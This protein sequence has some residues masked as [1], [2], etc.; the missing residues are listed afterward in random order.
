MG[1]PLDAD[2]Y[3]LLLAAAEDARNRLGPAESEF[4]DIEKQLVPKEGKLIKKGNAIK[5][6]YTNFNKTDRDRQTPPS[7]K[8]FANRAAPDDASD[9]DEASTHIS[10]MTSSRSSSPQNVP[11]EVLQLSRAS[12]QGGA[13]PRASLAPPKTDPLTLE[14]LENK[15]VLAGFSTGKLSPA[16][17]GL[18]PS[19]SP[20]SVDETFLDQHAPDLQ[21]GRQWS[22]TLNNTNNKDPSADS[23]VTMNALPELEGDETNFMD[24]GEHEYMNRD[25]KISWSKEPGSQSPLHRHRDDKIFAKPRNRVNQWLLHQL[26]ISSWARLLDAVVG[27]ATWTLAMR[28]CAL[29][30]WEDGDTSF[31]SSPPLNGSSV[32]SEISLRPPMIYQSLHDVSKDPSTEYSVGS[33]RKRALR[34][35]IPKGDI[36]S[37]SQL[38]ATFHLGKLSSRQSFASSA[39]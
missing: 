2:H 23:Y 16:Y 30:S 11:R 9:T 24:Q 29:T 25:Q 8:V 1:T 15:D 3:A 28:E 38:H 27:D 39:P 33:G 19:T 34:S 26:R 4:E 36:F 21:L 6:Q 7:S 31:A 18:E 14:P 5:R 10:F 32:P 17:S 13:P 35:R 37:P 20:S 22:F 12:D